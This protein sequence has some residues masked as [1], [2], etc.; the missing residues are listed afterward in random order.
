MRTFLAAALAAFL[1][2]SV[3]PATAQDEEKPRRFGAAYDDI[4]VL[5]YGVP[6]SDCVMLSFSCGTGKPVVNVNVRDEQSAAGEGALLHVRLSAG[7]ERI[8]FSE[9]AV[10]NQDSGGADVEGR[11]PPDDVL[12]RIREAGA[13]W[14]LDE[15]ATRSKRFR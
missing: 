11:L 8:E 13:G 5:A 14:R 2:A 6:D 7:G 9:E 3:W 15:D 12:R 10:L 4:T 1:P